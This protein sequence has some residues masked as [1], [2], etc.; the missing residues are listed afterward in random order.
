M[1]L[2][3]IVTVGVRSSQVYYRLAIVGGTGLYA[4]TGGQLTVIVTKLVPLREQLNF[5]IVA[6]KEKP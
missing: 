5:N 1:P 4:N 6:F 2:G 3:Q